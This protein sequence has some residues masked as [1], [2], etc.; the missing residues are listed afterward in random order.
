MTYEIISK[1]M[2]RERALVE[3]DSIQEAVEIFECEDVDHWEPLDVRHKA[4]RQLCSI[5]DGDS[6]EQLAQ[7]D[8]E[9]N[10]YDMAGFI[11]KRV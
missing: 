9:G 4:E 10:V 1:R 2:T 6:D 3:A 7:A 11:I 5:W 8:D